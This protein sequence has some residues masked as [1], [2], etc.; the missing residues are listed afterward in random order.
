[1]VRVEAEILDAWEDALD[2]QVVECPEGLLGAEEVPS[3]CRGAQERVELLGP[4]QG[5]VEVAVLEPLSFLDGGKIYPEGFDPR[6]SDACLRVGVK[7]GFPG[8]VND[9]RPWGETGSLSRLCFLVI[10][11]DNLKPY[12]HHVED[13]STDFE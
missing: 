5:A 7:G 6:E 1:M 12:F 3:L 13:H 2:I 4:A 11:N 10:T 8:L 9:G